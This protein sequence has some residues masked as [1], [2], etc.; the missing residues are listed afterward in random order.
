MT[1]E[2][3]IAQYGLAAVFAGSL[4][5]GETVLLL[6]G[7]AAHRGYLDFAAVVAVAWLGA[8]AGDQ[9]WFWLG[10]RH[11]QRWIAQRPALAARV[12]RALALIGRHPAAII[13]GMRFAWGMRIALPV[14]IGVSGVAARRFFW[15]NLLSAAL[16]APLVAGVGWGFGALI[17]RHAAAWHR[18]EHWGMAALVALALLVH[19]WRYWRGRAGRP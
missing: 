17:G 15:L 13:L 16:W 18:Y 7:Y 19:G 11:G 1:P 3:L 8:V 6:A 12:E 2:T 5:E 4:F 9:A 10:R 14:A